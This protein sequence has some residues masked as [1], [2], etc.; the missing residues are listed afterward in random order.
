MITGCSAGRLLKQGRSTVR[1]TLTLCEMLRFQRTASMNGAPNSGNIQYNTIEYIL[2]QA[3]RPISSTVDARYTMDCV[4]TRP[5]NRQIVKLLWLKRGRSYVLI[6]C[7]L[8]K[9]RNYLSANRRTYKWKPFR[10]NAFDTIHQ[11][12]IMSKVH[13]SAT[14]ALM[15]MVEDCDLMWP[16]LHGMDVRAI[17]KLTAA[18][19]PPIDGA[20]ECVC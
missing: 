2:F 19:P 5:L 12:S 8:Y 1:N 13:D 20:T 18:S 14:I 9:R 15:H 17:C 16:P 7:S 11:T 3:A 10:N 6:M 4:K